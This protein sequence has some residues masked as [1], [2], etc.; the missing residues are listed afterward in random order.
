[1]V[2]VRNSC[3]TASSPS[4]VGVASEAWHQVTVAGQPATLRRDEL[5]WPVEIAHPGS[6]VFATA[7]DPDLALAAAAALLRVNGE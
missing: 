6:T 3:L 2:A 7:R 5:G 1:M 4:F